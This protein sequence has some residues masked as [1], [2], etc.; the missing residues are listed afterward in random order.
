MAAGRGLGGGVVGGWRGAPGAEHARAGL[1]VRGPVGL[2]GGSYRFTIEGLGG[3]V[4]EV[5]VRLDPVGIYIHDLEVARSA[6][7]RGLGRVLLHAAVLFGARLGKG[8]AHLEADDDGSGRL[9]RWYRGLG[10][11]GVGL[12]AQGKPALAMNIGHGSR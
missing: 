10:F 5:R 1:G 2:P 12:G 11:H 8:V 4:G 3:E 7:G 6:R 9:L